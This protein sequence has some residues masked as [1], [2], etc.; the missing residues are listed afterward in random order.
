MNTLAA[1]ALVWT[2]ACAPVA[3]QQ[4]AAQ[5]RAQQ[6]RQELERHRA[7]SGGHGALPRRAIVS[8]TIDAVRHGIGP[9]D[10]PALLD[11]AVD[12]AYEV[13]SAAAALLALVDPQAQQHVRQ[14]IE[15][16]TEPVRRSRLE[17]VLIDVRS[18]SN[19]AE[20]TPSPGFVAE[21]QRLR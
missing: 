15:H 11:L 8:S 16:E 17:A 10:V 13:R 21:A 5:A 4:P 3:A 6:I 2:L 14:H 20:T 7:W 9:Q 1:T 18:R 19:G 12:E